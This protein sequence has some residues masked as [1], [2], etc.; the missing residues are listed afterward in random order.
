MC[1]YSFIVYFTPS[2]LFFFRKNGV[3][4]LRGQNQMFWQGTRSCGELGVT[5]S[6]HEVSRC[7][8]QKL[9]KLWLLPL[10]QWRTAVCSSDSL[11][12]RLDG[13]VISGNRVSTVGSGGSLFPPGAGGWVLLISWKKY[14]S[15]TC[16][17]ILFAWNYTP[18]F[19]KP[20]FPWSSPGRGA[21]GALVELKAKPESKVSIPWGSWVC[22]D[23]RLVVVH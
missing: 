9:W 8:L 16:T 5:S 19:L 4:Y 22:C 1:V 12:L 21:A 6:E 2:A 7:S 13:S 20:H 10:L 18:S 3:G 11:P 23:I 15:K 14:F 17:E